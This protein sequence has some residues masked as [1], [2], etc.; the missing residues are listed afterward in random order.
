MKVDEAVLWLL[1]SISGPYFIDVPFEGIKWV[2]RVPPDLLFDAWQRESGVLPSWLRMGTP[3]R[4]LWM[5]V[6]R[7]DS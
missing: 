6:W 3:G 1:N 5:F 2:A 7:H 4:P